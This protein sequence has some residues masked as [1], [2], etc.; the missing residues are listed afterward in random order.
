MSNL[1]ELTNA[2]L[3]L[4]SGGAILALRW[5]DFDSVAKT[6][7]IE[8]ALEKASDGVTVKPPK[9]ERGRRTITIDD[10]LCALLVAER[11]K[12]LRFV[13]GVSET[14]KVDLSLVK[15]PPDALI[16]PGDADLIEPRDPATVS[17]TFLRAAHRFGFKLR[18]HDLR[19][20]H[21][22][23]LLDNG[24]P[25]H[26]V[27]KRLGHS[28]ACCCRVMP[29]EPKRRTRVRPMLSLGWRRGYER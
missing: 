6:L 25:V 22:T 12:Y 29:S 3:D 20:T 24:V 23:M 15:L 26:I 19:G 8:R 27:A 16:F 18:F 14:A 11:D 21:G 5:T 17:L 2:E 28:A 1:R 13:A 9:T 10:G 7:R 4:V